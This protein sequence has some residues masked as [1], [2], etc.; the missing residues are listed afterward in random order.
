MSP[1]LGEVCSKRCSNESNY[2]SSDCGSWDGSTSRSGRCY[3]HNCVKMNAAV[4][5]NT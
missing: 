1:E 4:S 3:H 5:V 2:D